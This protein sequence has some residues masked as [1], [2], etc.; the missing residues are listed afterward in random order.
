VTL[1]LSS[2]CSNQLSYRPGI[3]SVVP[4]PFSALF[5]HRVSSASLFS[6]LIFSESP[7]RRKNWWR[8]G[9]S[10]PRPIACKAT[11]LPTELYPHL[12]AVRR[13]TL[14]S[15]RCFFPVASDFLFFVRFISFSFV[16]SLLPQAKTELCA[17]VSIYSGHPAFRPDTNRTVF[18]NHP[19]DKS[20]DIE[21]S[22]YVHQLGLEAD[23]LLRLPEVLNI[24][25]LER[26]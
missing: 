25:S 6:E 21:R 24:D 1:R 8:H 26:R 15:V 20:K 3:R 5:S 9:D 14:R 19:R 4:L 13:L 17:T 7:Y 11:A 16:C 22:T 23:K 2:A 18:W 12:A 10:N